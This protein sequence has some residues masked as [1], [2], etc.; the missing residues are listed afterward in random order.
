MSNKSVA[1][2]LIACSL[3]IS[4]CATKSYGRQGA[5]TAYEYSS[6]SCRE[7]QLD[8][9]RTRGFIKQVESESEFDG[10]D[11]LAFLGDFGIG[12]SM[13]KSAAMK[14]ANVRIEGLLTALAAKRC[15]L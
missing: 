4:G 9:G 12:N 14:S 1:I 5:L 13:E 7:L 8:L 3:A 6:M 10:K 15:A 2:A 11:V